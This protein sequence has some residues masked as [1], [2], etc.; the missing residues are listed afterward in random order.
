VCLI[1]RS[2]GLAIAQTTPATELRWIR[3]RTSGR[4]L[5]RGRDITWSLRALP[6]P[7]R[8]VQQWPGSAPHIAVRSHGFRLGKPTNQT[9]SWLLRLRTRADI[10]RL[11][12]IRPSRRASLPW[13]LRSEGLLRRLEWREGE[14]GEQ[15][16]SLG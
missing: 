5:S 1:S 4:Q 2:L 3:W 14:Q 15:T 11:G 13:L 9:R 10:L 12:G 6:P 7:Y 8:V 16:E